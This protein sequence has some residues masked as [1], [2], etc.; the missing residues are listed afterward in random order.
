MNSQSRIGAIDILKGLIIISILFLNVFFLHYQPLWPA[1]TD[2]PSIASIMAGILFPAFIFLIGVTI[3]F[4]ITKKINEGLKGYDI[5]RHLFARSLILITVGVLMVNTSRVE[6]ELT[7]LS[8]YLWA[9]ILFTGIFLTWNR[10]PEKENNFFTIS[11]LRL[12]GLA[13]LVFLV[14]RFRSGSL[15]NNGSLIPGWWELPGLAG[16]GYLIAGLTYLAFRNSLAGTF[17]IWAL[18]LLV[19]ILSWLNMTAFLDP[20]K[21]YFGVLL[22]GYI[23][24]IILTG[25]LTGIIVKKFPLNS[26]KKP[27]GIIL[28]SGILLI[29]AGIFLSKSYFTGSIFNNP[30][31][32]MISCGAT[33]ILFSIIFWLDEVMK[34]MNPA[35]MIKPAGEYFFTI[36]ILQFLLFNL[37]WLSGIEVFFF[38]KPGALFLNIA[39][40]LV[41]TLLVIGISSLLIRFNIRLRF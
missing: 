9:I 28:L 20:V 11:G 30:A 23:P 5:S 31:W 4:S 3:P 24:V 34:L 10:Y 29:V 12:I 37:V 41:W 38:L 22:D 21:P 27:L 17:A 1:N 32:A 18:F 2:A 33:A 6:P 36:Y 19:N 40:S 15:E 25:Q 13:T 35:I 8:R 7:G 14:F 16:W 26:S 39:G